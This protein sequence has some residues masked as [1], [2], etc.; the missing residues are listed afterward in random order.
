M[1]GGKKVKRQLS[2]HQIQDS[3][4]NIDLKSC[5]AQLEHSRMCREVLLVSIQVTHGRYTIFM[6]GTVTD[7]T[8]THMDGHVDTEACVETTGPDQSRILYH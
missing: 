2:P 8:D 5:E 4:T 3:G 6:C 1:R 7:K